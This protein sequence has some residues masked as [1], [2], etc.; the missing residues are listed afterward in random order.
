MISN[1]HE[2][3]EYDTIREILAHS[4]C[5]GNCSIC[6][7]ILSKYCFI[8]ILRPYLF[9]SLE[10]SKEITEPE[11]NYIYHIMT[12][13]TC[14][15]PENINCRDCAWKVSGK[16]IKVEVMSACGIPLKN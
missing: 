14:C 1:L 12:T 2:Q 4:A 16:C 8:G 13:Y 6:Q 10:G 5:N 3:E 9:C 15:H 11:L 7:Q